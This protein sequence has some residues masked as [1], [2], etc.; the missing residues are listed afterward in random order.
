MG[1]AFQLNE[2]FR[3]FI[4]HINIIKT[5]SISGATVCIPIGYQPT[6]RPKKVLP[7]PR[8]AIV[9]PEGLKSVPGAHIVKMFYVPSNT[10]FIKSLSAMEKAV[11]RIC[12][13]YV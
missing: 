3:D 11:P 4:N 13:A 6:G 10:M 7:I 9:S 5:S 8:G 2:D 1:L 12:D